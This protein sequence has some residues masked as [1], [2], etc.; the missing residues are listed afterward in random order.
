MSGAQ[1]SEWHSRHGVV[2][3]LLVL[4]GLFDCGSRPPPP[5][6]PT[7]EACKPIRPAVSNRDEGF[8]WDTVLA[9]KPSSVVI[10]ATD[11][12][13]E[14]QVDGEMLDPLGRPVA[15]QFTLRRQFLSNYSRTVPPTPLGWRV[16][17]G[18]TPELAGRYAI[19]VRVGPDE[20]QRSVQAVLDRTHEPQLVD[21]MPFDP[22]VCQPLL[23]TLN[24]LMMCQ[25]GTEAVTIRGGTIL[26]SLPDTSAH[27]VGN[28]VWVLTS[29]RLER[30]VDTGQGPLLLTGSLL[31]RDSLSSSGSF[32]EEA[33]AIVTD[34]PGLR[35]PLVWHDGGFVD[36]QLL[37]RGDAGLLVGSRALSLDGHQTC[38]VSADAGP[39][40]PYIPSGIQGDVLWLGQTY[41]VGGVTDVR[42]FRNEFLA[43]GGLVFP[44]NGSHTP[45]WVPWSP[46]VR[47]FTVTMSATGPALEWWPDKSTFTHDFVLVDSTPN[48]VTWVR[49]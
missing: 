18:F 25:R 4:L 28:T 36:E 43:V 8:E 35:G 19:K 31:A 47:R 45:R 29:Q 49:R 33:R 15:A 11:L 23:R 16:W 20:L 21:R 10:A 1:V 13:C 39:C 48:S 32:F 26:E 46:S 5:S 34:G 9:T 6:E 44:V 22:S 17:V 3:T 30:R 24:G 37:F 12:P 41:M 7:P 40:I 2:L 42:V 14:M 27:V 38:E